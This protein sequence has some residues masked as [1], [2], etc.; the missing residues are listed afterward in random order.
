M[1]NK[2]LENMIA[3]DEALE[4]IEGE[5]LQHVR[6]YLLDLTDSMSVEIARMAVMNLAYR[7]AGFYDATSNTVSL[8]GMYHSTKR[9]LKLMTDSIKESS[10]YGS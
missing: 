2:E 8:E 10:G 6:A 7:H 5:E 1:D 4:D 9:V 3:S